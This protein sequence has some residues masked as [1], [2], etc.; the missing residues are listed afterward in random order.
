MKTTLSHGGSCEVTLTLE[1]EKERLTPHLERAARRISR[2]AD[3][4]GYRRGRAPYHLVERMF[5]PGAIYEEALD[6]VGPELIQEALEEK[7]LVPIAQPRLSIQQLDPLILQVVVTL[8][9]E[10]KL[11]DYRS[12]RLTPEE[13]KVTEED[14]ASALREIQEQ[15]GE[16]ISVDRP[17]QYGDRLVLDMAGH[18]GE[19]ELF[20]LKE[21]TFIPGEELAVPIPGFSER[22]VGLVPDGEEVS[23]SLT[24]PEDFDDQELAGNEAMCQ[25]SIYDVR[26]NELPELNDELA[27]MVGDYDSLEDLK[28]NI[29][30]GLRTSLEAEAQ[31]RL[32]DDALRQVMEISEVEYPALMVEAEVEAMVA[33]RRQRLQRQGFTLEGYLQM[34]QQTEEG[35][36][37]E[38]HSQAEERLARSLILGKLVEAEGIE[39]GEEEV[40]REIDG[41]A[42]LYGPRDAEMLREGLSTEQAR[43]E[44]TSR[45]LAR[46]GIARL[47]ELV[48]GEEDESVAAETEGEKEATEA[49]KPA[50]EEPEES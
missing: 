4:P 20:E 37:E 5:G 45:I 41:V 48:V 19:R 15:N 46:K 3:V 17:V 33:E 42:R 44:L 13:V 22:L 10:V 7:E 30:E 47:T 12:I 28:E 6:E 16:W 43:E 29:R 26:E 21:T 36:R 1:V 49:G 2:Q 8:P 31:E 35:F 11:G 25:V 32:A 23:F 24:Y 38:L 40:Q 14:V 27:H 39:V 34:I 18:V 50:E 9:P